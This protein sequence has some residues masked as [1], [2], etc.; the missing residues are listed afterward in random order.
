[1]TERAILVTGTHR[2]GTTWVGDTL[3]LSPFAQYVH[4][5]FAPMNNRS[6]LSSPPTIRYLHQ[7][8]ESQG[9]YI[10]D[11]QRIVELRPRWLPVAQRAKTARDF[12]NLLVQAVTTWRTRNRG[13]RAVIK[14]PFA[15]LSAEWL[16]E[17]TGAIPIVL[18]R[19]PAGFVS[20][21]KRLNWRLDEKWLLCQQELMAGD[22]R[23][24]RDELLEATNLD[25]VDHAC[26]IWRALNSVVARLENDHPG[27]KVMRYED[28]ALDPLTGFESLYEYC[29]LA[30]DSSI[31]DEVAARNSSTNPADEAGAGPGGTSRFSR[32]AIWTWLN[33]LT[34][35]EINRIRV[36][37]ADVASRWYADSKWW[38]PTI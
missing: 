10:Q 20:S 2:S 9:P 22:L 3:C 13:G 23:L 8:P 27:W 35:E 15:L 30:W 16:Q 19:H 11:V 1:M 17:R 12:G 31:R 36:A 33:R 37:T 21:I 24:F 14:D 26:L 7:R 4:E 6:L 32:R 28:L 38:G 25:T 29:G 34:D 18:V 5:P